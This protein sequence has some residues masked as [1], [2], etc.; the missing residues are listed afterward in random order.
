MLEWLCNLCARMKVFSNWYRLELAYAGLQ[1]IRGSIKTRK[2]LRLAVRTL[3][4]LY[5][6][7]E[8]YAKK[9]YDIP[10]KT[11]SD[12][13]VID[14]GAYIGVF[15]LYAASMWKAKQVFCFEPCPESFTALRNNI[16][17]NK[18]EGVVF[19]FGQAVDEQSGIRDFYISPSYGAINSLCNSVLAN[20]MAVE[21]VTLKSVI[22]YNDIDFVD[23][24]KL[25]CEGVEWGILN[26]LDV[27]TARKIDVIGME[28]H[29]RPRGDF[30]SVLDRLGFEVLDAKD[31]EDSNLNIRAVQR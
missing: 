29:M 12:V 10:G 9:V 8:T 24:L 27:E 30:I 26:S 19:P 22:E 13:T 31:K 2:G 4:D 23:Y 20:K 18:L 6:L 15:S 17:T 25:D 7:D 16:E 28:F 1:E 21:C 11:F 5:V 3:A 14:V